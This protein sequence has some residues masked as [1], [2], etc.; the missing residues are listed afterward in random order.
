MDWVKYLFIMFL[1][2][3]NDMGKCLGYNVKQGV[4]A[5]IKL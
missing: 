2:N 3:I 1:E 5:W 4:K